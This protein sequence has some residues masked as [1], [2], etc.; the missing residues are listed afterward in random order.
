[1]DPTHSDEPDGANIKLNKILNAWVDIHAGIMIVAWFL[2]TF[3]LAMMNIE[4]LV[5]RTMPPM[6]LVIGFT[7]SVWFSGSAVAQ[8]R[9]HQ[10]EQHEK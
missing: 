8:F 4:Y 9:R 6:S 7:L 3:C 1:M 2:L 10:L 5:S